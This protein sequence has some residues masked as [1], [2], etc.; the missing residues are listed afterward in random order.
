MLL[1]YKKYSAHM[2]INSWQSL[3]P[4]PGPEFSS[5]SHGTSK[6]KAE[7]DIPSLQKAAS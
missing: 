7:N 1:G 4:F 5:S 6:H 2:G 3:S